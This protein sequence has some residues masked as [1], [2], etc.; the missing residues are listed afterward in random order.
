MVV[1]TRVVLQGREFVGQSAGGVGAGEEEEKALTGEAST[2]GG[3]G[4]YLPRV[5]SYTREARFPTRWDQHAVAQRR[6]VR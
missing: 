2:T 3:G 5:A 1:G 6:R 4:V